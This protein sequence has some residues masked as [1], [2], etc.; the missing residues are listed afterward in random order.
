[1]VGTLVGS[2]IDLLG[3]RGQYNP[4]M[5][6]QTLRF[7]LLLWIVPKTRITFGL[8]TLDYEY[9]SKVLIKGSPGRVMGHLIDK[10]S[11]YPIAV[12]E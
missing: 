2:K 9:K 5:T 12:H 10:L 8:F 7:F 11:V 4:D 1:M 6:M 3:H